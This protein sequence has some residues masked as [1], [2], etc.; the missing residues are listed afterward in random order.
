MNND[1]CESRGSLVTV[2]IFSILFFLAMAAGISTIFVYIFLGKF[3]EINQEDFKYVIILFIVCVTVILIC[4]TVLIISTNE[5]F[6]K[7]KKLNM[8]KSVLSSGVLTTDDIYKTFAD[9]VSEV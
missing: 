3:S 1:T 2:V 4:G 5:I 8:L 9:A 7:R 6:L